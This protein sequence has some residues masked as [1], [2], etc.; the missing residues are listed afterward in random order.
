MH[1][2]VDLVVGQEQLVVREEKEMVMMVVV[3]VVATMEAVEVLIM[4]LVQ[5]ALHLSQ[6]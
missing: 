1:R 3:V 4:E 6:D 2:K 5:E